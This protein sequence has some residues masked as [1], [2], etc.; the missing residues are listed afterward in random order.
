MTI[1]LPSAFKRGYLALFVFA[2]ALR[3]AYLLQQAA[4]NPLFDYPVVDAQVYSS[5]AREIL[6]G[7]WWWP[8]PRYYLPVYP[9]FLAACEWL[10]GSG[11]WGVKIVQAVLSSL[12]TVM[13]VATVGRSF[14]R[15]VGFA[16]GI[17]FATNWLFIVHDAERFSE[18]LCNVA[19]VAFFFFFLPIRR[20]YIQTALAAFAGAIACACRPNLLPLLV[21][22]ISWILI[23]RMRWSAKVANATAFVAIIVLVFGPILWHNHRLTGRWL[24]R[25]LQSWNLYA[26]LNPAFGGLHPAP[27]AEFKKYMNMPMQAWMTS[28]GAQEDYWIDQSISLLKAQ[29]RE[30]LFNYFVHRLAIFVDATE[31]NQEFDVYAFRNYASVLRPPWPAFGFVFSFAIAGFAFLGAEHIRKK[32]KHENQAPTTIRFLRYMRRRR[33]FILWSAIAIAAFTFVAK[34]TGRY[35]M[36]VALAM[37]P[38]A[39]VGFDRIFFRKPDKK[40]LPAL[41]GLALGIGASI[42][43]WADLKNRQTAHHELYIGMKYAAEGRYSEAE[44]A[45]LQAVRNQPLDATAPFELA[46]LLARQERFDEAIRYVTD[47]LSRESNYREAWNLKAS[48][49]IDLK[50]FELAL[51]CLDRSLNMYR[52]Q[53]EAWALRS[54]VYFQLGRWND[55]RLASEQAFA[56]GAQGSFRIDDGLRLEQR[57]DYREA[58]KQLTIAAKDSRLEVSRRAQAQMLVCDILVLDFEKTQSAHDCW[59]HTFRQFQGV[60]FVAERALFLMG[61]TPPEEYRQQIEAL[62]DPKAVDSLFF[63]SGVYWLTRAQREKA[64]SAFRE[65]LTRKPPDTLPPSE[66]HSRWAWEV[67]NHVGS[68]GG[69]KKSL[70]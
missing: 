10:L 29:P 19:L 23:S 67:V 52:E 37:I 18:S 51:A 38:Y 9:L 1:R 48:L 66:V 43:D 28:T 20:S 46:V 62:D 13:L 49:H 3:L 44:A 12:A 50:Q 55:W 36:P 58:I 32:R 65:F 57:G 30:V 25:T 54:Q 42:P 39:A 17:L 40:T 61:Q 2:L 4:N 21:V 70:P 33:S 64:E 8:E 47:A 53:H 7:Q 35:R 24:L 14:G 15:R 69:N 16:A 60:R 34:V 5:W 41:L 31:W 26:A 68:A 63:S 11:A 6:S 22:A 56:H 45:L 59:E 27:G